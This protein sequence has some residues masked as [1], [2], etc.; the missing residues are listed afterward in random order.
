[1]G[2]S[3]FD[4]NPRCLHTLYHIYTQNPPC[5]RRDPVYPYIIKWCFPLLLWRARVHGMYIN[6]VEN[7]SAVR[8]CI[9]VGAESLSAAEIIKWKKDGLVLVAATFGCTLLSP[10]HSEYQP[11]AHCKTQHSL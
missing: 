9:P 7:A 1:M 8:I 4:T 6:V 11:I 10:A 3:Y 2:I 5:F